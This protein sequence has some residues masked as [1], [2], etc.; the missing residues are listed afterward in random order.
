MIKVSPHRDLSYIEFRCRVEPAHCCL[1]KEEEDDGKPWYFNIKRYIKSKEYPPKA[2]INDKRTVRRL[3]ASFL[4][5][6][7]VLYK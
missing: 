5:S 1:K 2:S 4:L 7:N 3:A 6:R